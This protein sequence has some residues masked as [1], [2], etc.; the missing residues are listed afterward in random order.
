MLTTR[1][2]PFEEY[3]RLAGTEAEGLIPILRPQDGSV[4]V[5]ERDGVIVGC[6]TLMR[7]WHAECLWITPADRGRA[8][9]LRRLWL[10]LN[11]EAR[12]HGARAICTASDRD[13]VAS[14][15]QR[16]GATVVPGTPWVLQLG[17]EE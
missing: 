1:I 3:G 2:L 13:E 10:A 16:L 12:S 4:V 6:W 9:V 8:G 17:S 5:V 11:R 15:L 7:V 14:M